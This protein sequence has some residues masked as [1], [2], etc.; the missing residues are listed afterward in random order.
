[1]VVIGGGNVAYDVARSA[2]RPA[3][4][5]RYDVAR[6]ALRISGDKEVHVVCLESRAGDARRRDRSRTRA[7]RK[8]STCTTSAGRARSCHENGKVTGLRTVRCTAVFDAQRPL[9][10]ARSTRAHVEDIPA[11]SV[12]FAIGQ[13]SDLSF[14]DPADGVETE[15]G[16]IKVNRETYQ[17]TAP[18][19]FACG[20]IA[21]GAAPVHRR[22]RVGADRRPL[23]ARFPARHA[24]GRGGAQAVAAGGVHDGGALERACERE[25]P[26]VL[27]SDRRARFARDRR[28]AITTKRTRAGRRRAAC[29]ATSTRCSTRKVRGVQRLRGRLPGK[30]DPPG[31]QRRSELIGDFDDGGRRA[32]ALIEGRDHVHPLRACAPRAARLTRFS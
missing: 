23:D 14:L 13:T 3:R 8:A 32:P 4:R 24:H 25:N 15:R 29:A 2:V 27:E 5:C 30:P 28:G 10:P 18:D 11:D 6:S 16:L 22:H 31:G 26:P 12:I 1:M 21:H 7:P 20:D 19:V 9:Q 17:T